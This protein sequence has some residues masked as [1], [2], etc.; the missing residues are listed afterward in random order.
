MA[1]PQV[2]RLICI[3]DDTRQV[4]GIVTLSDL[5][6]YF[7]DPEGIDHSEAKTI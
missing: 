3:D 6:N 4:N 7:L 2:Y 5:L 1:P